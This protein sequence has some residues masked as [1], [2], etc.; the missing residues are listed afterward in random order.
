MTYFWVEFTKAELGTTYYT[1][2]PYLLVHVT[3][4]STTW[5]VA[6]TATCTYGGSSVPLVVSA[7]VSPFSDVSLTLAVMTVVTG[8]DDPSE[9]ITPDGTTI[10]FSTTVTSGVL[11]FDC[12]SA[13]S[14]VTTP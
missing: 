1:S 2:L 6:S 14:T 9:N 4:E 5:T 8:D 10:T 11:S 12:G 7:P 3:G 13:L